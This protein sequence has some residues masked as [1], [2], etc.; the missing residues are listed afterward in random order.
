MERR[1]SRRPLRHAAGL[2]LCFDAR[3]PAMLRKKMTLRVLHS[4]DELR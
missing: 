1:P 4:L 2:M 3:I